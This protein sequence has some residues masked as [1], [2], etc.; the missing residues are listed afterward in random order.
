MGLSNYYFQ[1]KS[2]FTMFKEPIVCQFC[3]HDIFI[4]YEAFINVEEPGILVS[5]IKDFLICHHCGH[6]KMIGEQIYSQKNG[7]DWSMNQYLISVR[8][9]KIK[10]I[11]YIGKRHDDKL[12]AFL[13]KLVEQNIEIQSVHRVKTEVT[14]LATTVN[15]LQTVRHQ[16]MNSAKRLNVTIKDLVIT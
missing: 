15:E 7:I 2:R 11:F 10:M 16:I 4:P 1:E 14:I 8:K 6:V 13:N 5:Y 9:Y 3:S 12:T